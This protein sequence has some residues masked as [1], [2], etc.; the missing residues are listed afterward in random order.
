M[1]NVFVAL[2]CDGDKI[3]SLGCIAGTKG[4]YAEM[5]QTPENYKK[6][7][8]YHLCLPHEHPSD[9]SNY[10]SW[11]NIHKTEAP[12]SIMVVDNIQE[13]SRY[14]SDWFND[15]YGN[16]VSWVDYGTVIPRICE[17]TIAL[18]STSWFVMKEIRKLI[19][20]GDL[21]IT[22]GYTIMENKLPHCSGCYSHDK[23]KCCQCYSHIGNALSRAG[24]LQSRTV[25]T[26][27]EIE[28][29]K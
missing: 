20:E 13:L 21:Y 17:G 12:Q 25:K 15:L 3:I 24:E 5:Y 11:G 4:F 1:E 6:Y 22:R 8:R 27:C 14:L 10:W 18:S 9:Q 2:N 23:D 7:E 19:L 29:V 28:T 26:L 16:P